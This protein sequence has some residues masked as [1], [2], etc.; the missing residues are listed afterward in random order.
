MSSATSASKFP[1]RSPTRAITRAA[2]IALLAVAYFPI[3][4]LLWCLTLQ[5]PRARVVQTFFKGAARLMGLRFEMEGAPSK[6]RPLMIVANHSSY[7]DIFVIG[8]LIPISFAPKR[9]VRKWPLIGFLCVLADCVFVE[10]RATHLNEARGEMAKRIGE[11]RVICLFPEGTTSDGK[12]LKPFKS[13]FLSLAEEHKLPVQPLSIAYTHVGKYLLPDD[14]RDKVAWIGD[15]TFFQHFVQVLSY[16]S[17][18]VV[19][20]WHEPLDQANFEGR[21]ELT[22]AAFAVVNGG[23]QEMLAVSHEP[24]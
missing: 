6:L 11:G 17:I 5:K 14:E 13:A 22:K 7:I 9:E 15:S 23:V 12:H 10:R 20:R 24:R 8:S 21:K 3:V 2:L 19:L 4:F 16:P 18:R 1:W